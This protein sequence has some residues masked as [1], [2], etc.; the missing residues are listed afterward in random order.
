MKEAAR[1]EVEK[2]ELLTEK[3]DLQCT[4]KKLERKLALK[5]FTY[6]GVSLLDSPPS[7]VFP[8]VAE[9]LKS[10]GGPLFFPYTLGSS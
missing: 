3:K 8:A 7:S 2:N 10:P 9:D 1:S 4:V 5:D 6:G